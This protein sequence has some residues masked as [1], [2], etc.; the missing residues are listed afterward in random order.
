MATTTGGS[1]AWNSTTPN[2]PWPGGT[3]PATT[4]PILIGDGHTLTVPTGY[5]ARCG[6]G[7]SISATDYAIRTVG[8]SGTGVLVV[9]AGGTLECDA[10]VRQG[11]VDWTINGT[12]L[13]VN[14]ST[15]LSWQIGTRS[16]APFGRLYVEGT[17]GARARIGKLF[18]AAGWNSIGG[19]TGY[20]GRGA[21][22]SRWAKFEYIG[23]SSTPF[24]DSHQNAS[25]FNIHEDT[26]W[27][28]CGAIEYLNLTTTSQ[29][30]FLRCASTNPLNSSGYAVRVSMNASVANSGVVREIQHCAFTGSVAVVL[31]TAGVD[32]GI[33][34]YDVAAYAAT[35]APISIGG[36]SGIDGAGNGL[37]KRI[38]QILAYQESGGASRCTI[39]ATYSGIATQLIGIRQ[40]PTSESNADYWHS[41]PSAALEVDCVWVE[42][43]PGWNTSTGAGAAL[44][45]DDAVVFANTTVV[46]EFIVSRAIIA[47]NTQGL[48]S[49]TVLTVGG[50]TSWQAGKKFKVRKSTFQGGFSAEHGTP[51]L[52]SGSTPM[53]RI[54]R[55]L[56]WSPTAAALQWFA[57]SATVSGLPDGLLDAQNNAT[58]N[59]SG[60]P[61][62]GPGGNPISSGKYLTPVPNGD[63]SVNPYYVDASRNFLTFGRMV[64]NDPTLK[65]RRTVFDLFLARYIDGAWDARCTIDNLW[66]WLSAGHAPRHPALFDRGA[67]PGNNNAR[68]LAH[69]MI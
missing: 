66:A 44:G 23:T 37:Y 54:E 4:E 31:L 43:H 40:W 18:G 8:D 29:F 58:Y 26:W 53:A 19:P 68:L 38:E 1:G 52:G 51:T 27:D 69:G 50:N 34:V 41:T 24:S 16:T 20:V 5:T 17:S 49:G 42:Q 67:V 7:G 57:I 63:V 59:I 62:A 32:T 9:Q 21:I 14:T 25:F 11:N 36:E 39:G 60:T 3:I 22:T 6:I 33:D 10:H 30:R 13:A 64:L 28:N 47:P 55:S 12:V 61:Y 15:R 35:G 2:A 65:D 46:A 56:M 45:S 48:T